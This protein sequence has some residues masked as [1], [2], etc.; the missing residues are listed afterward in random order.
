MK[1]IIE[2]QTTEMAPLKM[3]GL[4]V[5]GDCN[6]RCVYCYASEHKKD[7]MDFSTAK[8]ALDIAAQSGAAFTLQLTGGEP[9][10]NFELIQEILVYVKSNKINAIPQIQ[11]NASLLNDYKARFLKEYGCAIGVSLD[12]KPAT[13]DRLRKLADGSGASKQI[14]HGL[15]V[16]RENN[17]ACGLTC[18]VTNDNVLKLPSIVDIAYYAGNVRL[19]GFDL[20]RGQG[21]GAVLQLPDGSAVHKAITATYNRAKMFEQ[22]TGIRIKFA[23]IER[24][25]SLANN[26]QLSFGH[27]YAMNG[28]AAFV[29]PCGEIYACSSLV[30]D[31]KFY[32]GN[33]QYGL[34]P[35]LLQSVAAR[36]Q[37]SMQPCFDCADFKM[38]GG[39]C[40]ARWLGSGD[41]GAYSGE[42]AL[43]QGS[44]H[45]YLNTAQPR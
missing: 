34:Q 5:T 23:Q 40:Y 3:L 38:C 37:A 1:S 15:S 27:C 31:P 2:Q 12:G 26:P 24:V 19:I 11:T 30:G 25:N 9:L 7:H 10:L 16:L 17:I 43:K 28:Q 32:L 41:Q 29:S 42:C 6:F 4:I 13:N 33:V 21:R 44:I 18:V 20:L 35:A 14:L 39:G 36:I 45:H 8:K 22:L